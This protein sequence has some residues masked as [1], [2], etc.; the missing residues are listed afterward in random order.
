MPQVNLT[1]SSEE[2]ELLVVEAA[3]RQV[4]KR[5]VIRISSLAHEL[6]KPV[7]AALTNTPPNETPTNESKSDDKPLNDPMA[8]LDI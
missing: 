7:I 2:Y 5:K 8:D 3:K 4:E 1:L 6:L